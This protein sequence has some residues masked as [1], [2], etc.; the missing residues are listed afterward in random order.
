MFVDTTI[1]MEDDW[2]DRLDRAIGW[3]LTALLLFMPLA[4]GVVEA[5]SEQVVIFLVGM[6]SVC[7]LLKPLL[8]GRVS[9]T[10]TWAYVPVA[11]IV[12]AIVVQLLPLP[13]GVVRLISPNTVTCKTELLGDLA[14]AREVL[15]SMTISFYP[16]ATKHDLRLVLAVVAVFLVVLNVYRRPDQILRLL[17]TIAVIGAGIAVLALA[18]NIIGNGKIYWCVTS[19]HGVAHSGPFVNHSHYGQ[20]MNLSIGAALAVFFVRVRGDF[21]HRSVTPDAIAEYLGSPDA[22]SVWGLLGMV[23]LGATTVFLAMSRGG[24]I[25]ML[26]AGALTT[27]VLS[28]KKPL[29][30][31]GWIIALLALGAFVCVLYIGFDAVYDRLAS[32]R[33]ISHA[34]GGRWQIIKDVSVAWARFPVLGTGLGTHEVVYPM[35]DRSQIPALASHAENE[36]AQMAEE[37]G[38]VGLLALVAFGVFVGVHYV[39]ATRNNRQPIVAAGLGLGFGL[40]AI[41]VHS[42][43][44]FGQHMPANAMLT[45]IFCGLLIRLSRMDVDGSDDSDRPVA[46]VSTRSRWCWGACL[47]VVGVVWAWGFLAADGARAAEAHWRKVRLAEASFMERRWEGDHDDYIY[48]LDQAEKAVA[49]EPDNVKYRHW[50]NVYRWHAISQTKDPN[51]GEITLSAEALEFVERIVGDLNLARLSCPT[52]GATWCVLGQ[53]ERSVLGRDEDGARHIR[54]GVEVAPCHPTARLVAGML[55]LEEGEIDVAYRHLSVAVALDAQLFAEVASVLIEQSHEP[56]MALQIAG[57]DAGHLTVLVRALEGLEESTDT[58]KEVRGKVVALLEK[59]CTLPT[60]RAW[61]FA[62]LA[63]TYTQDGRLEKAIEY[64]GQALDRDYG[65]IEWRFSLA[66][67]LAE[68]GAVKE[69]LEEAETC[70][71]FHP[72]HAASKELIRRLSVDPQSTGGS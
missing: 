37:M 70:L 39:R 10:L 71:R 58:V 63:R 16:H 1:W 13:Q 24:V 23:V 21:G 11:I 48:L 32:L 8:A 26:F 28:L 65:R 53:L 47:A 30:G 57:E 62:T 68:T 3:L 19:P 4:F 31:V 14:N 67:L 69:A 15:S 6:I 64:Y 56:E 25:S 20:F 33:D 55:A 2:E 38:L 36:Y 49:C 40:V 51:T 17:T 43:S 18:Q 52:F 44:D 34:E 41:L 22:K 54:E 27:L 9:V 60:A 5:W 50:L 45:A 12:L 35:F 61:V 59:G 46:S 66:R 72:G 29:G 7:F 42:L